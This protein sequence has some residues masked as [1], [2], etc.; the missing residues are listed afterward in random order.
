MWKK[1][2][3]WFWFTFRN[4]KVRQGEAGGFKWCFRRLDMTIETLSGNFKA[5]FTAAEN[6]YAYLLAGKT[7]E[8]II[9]F[10]QM[11]YT[12]GMLLTTDQ[13]FV[14]DINKAIQKYD[15]RLQKANPVVEDETEE[16]IALE[17]VKQVEDYAKMAS[18]ERKKIDNKFKSAIKKIDH[19]E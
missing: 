10:C 19:E 13:G 17:E 18:S 2:Q 15:K 14:D 3:T 4:P 6:P 11:I 5:R 1:I 9:G 16:K 8:N 12:V 7:D